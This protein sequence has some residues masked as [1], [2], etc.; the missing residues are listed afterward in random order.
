MWCFSCSEVTHDIQTFPRDA[1]WPPNKAFGLP[2]T[3]P[4]STIICGISASCKVVKANVILIS[5]ISTIDSVEAYYPH[6]L[7]KVLV[8]ILSLT[9]LFSQL[10]F[11]HLKSMQHVSQGRRDLI[12]AFMELPTP[13]KR[14]I[15][16]IHLIPEP[17]NL[18]FRE[19]HTF[20]K[21]F[22]L[23]FG[24]ICMTDLEPVTSKLE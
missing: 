9:L 4:S 12:S 11:P 7:C 13:A 22:P 23:T 24:V 18:Q 8:R 19:N 17:Y 6:A 1:V 20:Y 3:H 21:T 2:A 5:S 14:S 15:S 10:V 16:P